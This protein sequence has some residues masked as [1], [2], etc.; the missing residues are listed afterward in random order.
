MTPIPPT[1]RAVTSSLQ[2]RDP[3]ITNVVSRIRLGVNLDLEKLVVQTQLFS[4]DSMKFAAAAKLFLRTPRVTLSLFG[5]GSVVCTGAKNEEEAREAFRRLLTILQRV[6]V[7]A[8]MLD[9]KIEN[10]VAAASTGFEVHL[11]RLHEDHQVHC[12]YDCDLFPGA[13]YT[14][15]EAGI[16]ILIFKSGMI[17][18]CG[19]KYREQIEIGWQAFFN[20]V[21]LK[22]KADAMPGNSSDYRREERKYIPRMRSIHFRLVHD[23]SGETSEWSY[24]IL[25][26]EMSDFVLEFDDIDDT[27]EMNNKRK[28]EL[29]K[30]G[31]SVDESDS[32]REEVDNDEMDLAEDGDVTFELSLAANR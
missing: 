6:G 7:Q 1:A 28:N 20:K 27:S 30:D 32:S 5:S 25:E 23:N 8:Q 16:W 10:I 4:Y 31:A 19:A 17:I 18:M 26:D 24:K 3:L 29:A 2:R 12:E 14:F 13:R 15:R 22:Y 11:S 9:F 21:L